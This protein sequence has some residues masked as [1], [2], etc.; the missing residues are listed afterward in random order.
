[1]VKKDNEIYSK[2][3]LDFF[4]SI[5]NWNY[6]SM[7]EKKVEQFKNE[8]KIIAKN[9]IE[10]KTRKKALNIRLFQEDI[11]KIKAMAIKEGLPY[12]TYLASIIHKFSNWE[13]KTI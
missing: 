9:T 13:Y 8:A 2:D 10:K 11:L 5:E 12:Q 3:E 6:D 4:K 7:S 1:M